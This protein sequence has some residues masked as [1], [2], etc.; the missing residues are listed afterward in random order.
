VLGDKFFVL[1]TVGSSHVLE[2]DAVELRR[3]RPGAAVDGK[4]TLRAVVDL[5]ETVDVLQTLGNLTLRE[6]RQLHF[7]RVELQTQSRAA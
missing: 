6:Q 1:A 7:G 5:T 3:A 4:R 2:L